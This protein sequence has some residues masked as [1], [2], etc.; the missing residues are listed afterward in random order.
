M[1][2]NM[3]K[4]I[5]AIMICGMFLG[6]TNSIVNTKNT[7]KISQYEQEGDFDVL[8]FGATW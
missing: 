5:L 7:D 3:K 2:A 8:Y 4:T 1:K 6:C